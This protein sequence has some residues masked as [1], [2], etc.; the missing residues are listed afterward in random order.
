MKK[1]LGRNPKTVSIDSG[2]HSEANVKALNRRRIDVYAATGKQKH[3]E[4]PPPAPRGPIPKGLSI[5]DRM[6]RKL[7][8]KKGQA[9]YK[10]RKVIVEPVF[11]QIKNRG[12]RR[13][14]FRGEEL[15]RQEWGFVC[16]THDLLK[17][18][19]SRK[20]FRLN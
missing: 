1:N 3:S 15:V 2:C 8:T 20:K 16:M 4:K 14:S 17:L 9:A 5:K 6:R 18:F 19:K 12:F 11:G 13:F 10:K 7:R